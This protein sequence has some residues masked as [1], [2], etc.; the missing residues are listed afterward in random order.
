MT[1][2]QALKDGDL[3]VARAILD[4][5]AE[6]PDAC[7]HYMPE[8]YADLAREYDRKGRH[9]DAIAL[10]EHAIEL[11]WST[12]PDARSD[13]AEFHLRAGRSTEAAAICAELKTIDP[14][15]VWLYNAAGLSH[16]EVGEN[17]LAVA[18]LGEG[19]E[20]AMRTDD[21]EGIIN[22]LSD[23]RRHSVRSLGRGL[24]ELEQRVDPFMAEWSS[25]KRARKRR[26]ARLKPGTSASRSPIA[27]A[28]E[29]SS[30]CRSPG[31]PQASTRKR[32]A[33]GRASPRTG[34]TSRTPTTARVSTRTS[35]GC[36]A[37]A[38]RSAPS[39]QS[40]STTTWHGVPS[41]M[42]IPRTRERLT[43]S[44]A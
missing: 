21:P 7:D 8:C 44:I 34:R 32:S 1:F 27:T 26:L 25:E 36:A 29:R 41:T 6:L 14:D 30:S 5:L 13:I 10:H 9:D 20:L 3:D 2:E 39:R 33:A 11:G 17:E 40:S 16:N 37:R 35:N 24:D 18:W 19:I 15:D 31:S 12:I 43:R 28:S 22:Q 4:E 38:C 42:R 23:I